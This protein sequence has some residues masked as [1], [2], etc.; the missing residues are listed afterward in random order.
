VRY[1]GA[2]L[3][4][5]M[6]TTYE[7]VW[8][9]DEIGALPRVNQS[10]LAD[11]VLA[12][13]NQSSGTFSELVTEVDGRRYAVSSFLPHYGSADAF[14]IPNVMNTFSAVSILARIGSLDLINETK[15][16]DFIVACQ[17]GNGLFRPF[18]NARPIDLTNP[19]DVDGNGTGIPY[20][21]AAVGALKALGRL[22]LL[23]Q[24]DRQKIAQYI[25][26]CQTT[27][28]KFYIHQD[29]D[30]YY[31][32]IYTNHAVLTL[33]FIGMQEEAGQALLKVQNH[34]MQSQQFDTD[35]GFPLPLPATYDS[36]Y[37]FVSTGSLYGL[38]QDGGMEPL[39]DTLYAILTLNAT[40]GLSLL[41]QPT[42][43]SRVVLLNIA[44]LS[45]A[46]T[47]LVL[48]V[49]WG[50]VAFKKRKGTSST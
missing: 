47:A 4:F 19:F 35:A 24:G 31:E 11:F 29:S 6:H 3:G 37:E 7:V 28:G 8:A 39:F 46:V 26:A 30:D 13:Y 25:L 38:F 14:A 45:T 5:D 34:I 18:P 23:S 17:A 49:S 21:Y 10:S 16:L 2:F 42:T 15:I 1:D 36:E 9:L 50:L 41:D 20:T 33:N 48:I 40:N 22:E 32:P 27:N 43:R 12:R 44:I